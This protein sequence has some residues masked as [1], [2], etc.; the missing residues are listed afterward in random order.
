MSFWLRDE[1]GAEKKA[2]KLSQAVRDARRSNYH[3]AQIRQHLSD[4]EYLHCAKESEEGQTVLTRHT[5]G[6][7]H[8]GR[9]TQM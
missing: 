8:V 5:S 4:Q 7:P 2:T 9:G 6:L 1:K 3:I